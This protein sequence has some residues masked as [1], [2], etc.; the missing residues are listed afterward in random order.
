MQGPKFSYQKFFAIVAGVLAVYGSLF[1]ALLFYPEPGTRVQY[2]SL[3]HVFEDDT[4][5]ISTVGY[6]SFVMAWALAYSVFFRFPSRFKVLLVGIALGAAIFTP[7]MIADSSEAVIPLGASSWEQLFYGYFM[8]LL[9]AS[10]QLLFA[11]GALQILKSLWKW[12]FKSPSKQN[13]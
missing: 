10:F 6:L 5:T 12:T 8:A 13:R 4:A 9:A 1:A 11:A 3:G 7:A 2:E